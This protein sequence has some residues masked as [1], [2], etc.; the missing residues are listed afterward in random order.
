MQTTHSQTDGPR[1]GTVGTTLSQKKKKKLQ[2]KTSYT[3]SPY[4]LGQ[5]GGYN[6]YPLQFAFFLF[7]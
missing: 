4:F 3:K 5:T 6:K 7:Q 1:D 2:K